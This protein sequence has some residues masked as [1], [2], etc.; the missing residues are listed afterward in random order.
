LDVEAKLEHR[1][2]K[3]HTLKEEIVVLQDVIKGKDTA[4]QQLSANVLNTANENCR[5]S[6]MVQ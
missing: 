4:I 3:E 5:L 2:G 6:E 1:E